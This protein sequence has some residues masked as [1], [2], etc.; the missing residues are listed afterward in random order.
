MDARDYWNHY[1]E[2]HGGAVAVASR[3]G[4]PYST[5]AGICNGSRGIGHDIAERMAAADPLLDAGRLVWVRATK[6][7]P[8]RRATAAQAGGAAETTGTVLS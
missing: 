6:A 4:L 3:L 1:V 5:V 7:A 8:A 2:Q